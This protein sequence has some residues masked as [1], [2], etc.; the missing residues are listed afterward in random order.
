M[1]MINKTEP[2]TGHLFG[3]SIH[4][5]NPF[6]FACGSSRGEIVLWDYSPE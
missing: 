6:L 2:K 4:P 5:E 3:N 1:K